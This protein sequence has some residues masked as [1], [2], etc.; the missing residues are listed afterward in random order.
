MIREVIVVEGKNDTRRL[1]EFF[2]V[3]TIETHGLGLSEETLEYIRKVNE[4]RGV[5]L[6]LD[7]D[8][9]GEKIRKKLNEKIPGLKNAFVMKEDARTSRKVGIEHASKDVLYEA[10]ENLVTYADKPRS[11]SDRDF[12]L[13]G[14]KGEKDSLMK[15]ERVS[16]YYHIGRCNGKT[17]LKRLNMLGVTCE[18]IRNVLI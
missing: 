10:L 2:D 12:Y 14:L 3:D 4:S 1:Q 6:F 8:V 9:P 15:R 11:L 17:M 7:P 16:R 5:I 18:E 13:L